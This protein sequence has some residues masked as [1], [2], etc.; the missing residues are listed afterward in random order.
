METALFARSRNFKYLGLRC[1]GTYAL[2]NTDA[3][4]SFFCH[5]FYARSNMYNMMFVSSV[6]T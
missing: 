1:S 4:Y 2:Y 3:S 6:A 5:S